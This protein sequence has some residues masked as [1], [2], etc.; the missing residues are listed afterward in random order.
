LTGIAT[1]DI[2]PNS[3]KKGTAARV[4]IVGAN[5]AGLTAAM[6]LPRRYEVTVLDSQ[7]HFEFLPN[8]H[9]LLSGVKKPQS[10]RLDRARLIERTGHRFRQDTVTSIDPEKKTVYTSGRKKVS[11][12]FCVVAVGGVNNTMGINGAAKFG[13]P[14]KSVEQCCNIAGR[15]ENLMRSKHAASIVIVGGGLEGIEALGEILRRYRRNSNLEINVIEK[16]KKLLSKESKALD[17][18]VRKTCAPYS[19]QFH[20]GTRV[21]K[22][23]ERKVWLS[24]REVLDSD[25]T[26]WTGGAA[27]P[28]LL[29][30]SGL[31]EQPGTWAPVTGS[32]QSRCHESIFV[33]GDAADL[34]LVKSK[35]AY[36][37]MDMGACVAE[38][39][40]SLA[41]GKSLKTFRP[42]SKPTII[43]FGDLQTYV[44]M[45]SLVAAGAVLA[46]AKEAAY[47][48]A[49][50]KFDP[51]MG[52]F[53]FLRFSRRAGDSLF[54]LALPAFTSFSS[55]K[56][57]TNVRLLS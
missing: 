31:A 51:P 37:A 39:I 36:H 34:E 5:F 19:V 35:Q 10:L 2:I 22:I 8:I 41:A 50:A 56:R 49:M 43:S 54:N 9:E 21:T 4:V 23:N 26:I 28:P 32:L 16:N 40:K 55:L 33:A 38:N 46:G 13:L 52:P 6:N 20:T 15:L 17:S 1:G 48:A 30:K 24:S 25:A 53:S 27:P 12:D 29:Q 14:F 18:D 11:Y 47:Q 3:S 7:P 44:I 45:G 42:A 57:M